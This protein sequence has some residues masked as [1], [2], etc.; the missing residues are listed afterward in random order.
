MN[1]RH[2]RRRRGRAS[3]LFMSALVLACL[4][5]S[6]G[7]VAVGCGSDDTDTTTTA[8]TSGDTTT[9]TAETA[10]MTGTELGKAVG[11]TWNEA[12]QALNALLEG[13]PEAST[14]K[15]DVES[16]R[17]KYIQKMVG[18]AEQRQTMDVAAQTEADA[19]TASSLSSVAGADWYT[20]YMDNWDHYSYAS[21]DIEFSN[22]LASFNQLQVYADFE[23]LKTTYP[24]EATRLGV[25]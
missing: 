15:A 7:L 2:S 23:L 5:L 16:L 3:T 1:D 9:T 13:Q 18:F 21:G 25:K 8:A 14:V 11:A 22:L 20:T 10:D 12:M 19:A 17:E 24:D 4:V 6:I